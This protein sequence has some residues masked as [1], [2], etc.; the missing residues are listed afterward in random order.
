MRI[1]YERWEELNFGDFHTHNKRCK[2]AE[3]ELS[4][5]VNSAINKDLK[6]IG[7]SDHFPA[8]YNEGD[9]T[10]RLQQFAMKENEVEDYLNDAKHL[11][12]LYKEKIDVKI[13]FEVGYLDGKEDNYSPRIKELNGTIDYLIGS[14]H[15]L[16]LKGKYWGI[17][18]QDLQTLVNRYGTKFVYSYYFKSIEKMLLSKNFDL[19]I[20]GHIDYIKNGNENPY[21][22]EFILK[23]MWKLMPLIKEK[24]VTVEINTQ[25]LRNGYKKLYPCEEVIKMLFDYGIPVVLSSDAHSPSQVGYKFQD[26]IQIIKS[27]GYTSVAAF[28]KRKIIPMEL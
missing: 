21:L 9:N 13:G 7:L 22:D 16:K 27:I 6:I 12:E 26:V 11:K 5:Y 15:T 19:D 20:I 10:L 23:E 1:E 17:K 18:N 14:V 4:E 8:S 3:G 2:H 25:G 24:E 28:N